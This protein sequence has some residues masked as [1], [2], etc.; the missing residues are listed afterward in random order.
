M[1]RYSLPYHY[2]IVDKGYLGLHETWRNHPSHFLS[3][4]LQIKAVKIFWRDVCKQFL[5]SRGIVKLIW[6]CVVNQNILGLGFAE[7]V[8][9]EL[10][11]LCHCFSPLNYQETK[12]EDKKLLVFGISNNVKCDGRQLYVIS[13]HTA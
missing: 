11:S 7:W 10:I 3:S 12:K 5:F 8:C 13:T 4:F 2:N 6:D 9:V 1:F